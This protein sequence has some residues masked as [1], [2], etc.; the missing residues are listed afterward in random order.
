MATIT[1][2]P[3]YDDASVVTWLGINFPANKPVEVRNK[4]LVKK[5]KTNPFFEV[6]DDDVE[7]AQVASSEGE[8]PFDR[9]VAA[10]KAG[11]P[12]NAPGRWSGNRKGEEWLE[13]YD[14]VKEESNKDE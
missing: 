14:S 6:E 9:G 11:K 10:A 8:G 12:R 7:D 4:E 13:G 5:A 1:Y 2:K 3:S